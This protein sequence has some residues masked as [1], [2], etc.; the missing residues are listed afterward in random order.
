MFNNNSF[1]PPQFNQFQTMPQ[2][3]NP[4]AD[5]YRQQ[6]QQIAQPQAPAQ[7]F[8]PPQTQINQQMQSQMNCRPVTSIDEAKGAMIDAFGIYVFTDFGNGKIYTKQITNNG[9]AEINT[10]LLEVPQSMQDEVSTQENNE[11]LTRLDRI[12]GFLINQTE[13]KGDGIDEHTTNNG[14]AKRTGKSATNV[15]A[16]GK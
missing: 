3:Y 10:F 8:Q 11:I 15:N 1:Q 7:Q 4:N 16:D 2:Q 5:F 14:I 12:E 6:M 9:T 13:I